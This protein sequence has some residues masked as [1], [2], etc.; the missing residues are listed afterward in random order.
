MGVVVDLGGPVAAVPAVVGEDGQREAGSAVGRE[1]EGDR[2][3]LARGAGDG[4]NTG[5]SDELFTG[6]YKLGA[7][8]IAT[9]PGHPQVSPQSVAALYGA[10]QPTKGAELRY[11][12]VVEGLAA[13]VMAEL[14][15]D[16][17]RTEVMP[18]IETAR[19]NPRAWP[20]VGDPGSWEEIREAFGR[21]CWIQ[22][23]GR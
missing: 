7:G 2:A 11:G 17:A 12:V 15:N 18:L 3:G 16:Q 14:P 8:Q 21:W 5:F 1:A 19:R 13:E 23:P 20:D 9:I 4:N 6:L 22:G 10:V